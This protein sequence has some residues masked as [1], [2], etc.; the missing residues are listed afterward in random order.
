MPIRQLV[1]RFIRR[2]LRAVVELSSEAYLAF[3]RDLDGEVGARMRHAYYRKRLRGLGP[4]A[5][6]DTGVSMTGLEWI[7]I[8]D[9]THIDKGCYLVACGPGLDLSK[10]ALLQVPNRAID[11]AKG[12]LI[13]GEHCHIA[14]ASQIHAHGGVR[15]GDHCALATG[16][17][18]F[19]LTSL[20]YNP[21]NPRQITTV[22]P[23][24]GISP[25]MIGP[26]ELG[27]N[28]MMGIG[29]CVLPGVRIG[30]DSFVRTNSVVLQSF[31]DNSSIAGDPA[32]FKKKR[33]RV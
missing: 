23:F 31:P 13:I 12:E 22:T 15:I 11:V 19:S 27:R 21:F 3:I 26:I 5:R 24:D 29:V 1:P 6:I 20:P 18:I 10:R 25:S 33:F 30:S 28:V 32:E 4:N 8:G 2:R 17:K 7:S 16:T 14:P 9:H